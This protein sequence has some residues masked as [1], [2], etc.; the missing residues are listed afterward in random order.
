MQ[1]SELLE[2]RWVFEAFPHVYASHS[3]GKYLE[4]VVFRWNEGVFAP[5]RAR[6]VLAKLT[7]AAGWE[8]E[9]VSWQWLEAHLG[10]RACTL[11]KHIP[12]AS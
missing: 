4:R 7:S 5:E 3:D 11:V 6:E 12:G 8:I 2:F 10:M 1:V 9:S